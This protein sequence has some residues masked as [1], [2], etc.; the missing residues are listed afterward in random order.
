MPTGAIVAG[1]LRRPGSDRKAAFAGYEAP[2]PS[3]L[4]KAGA[5]RF[6]FCIPFAEPIL[7]QAA[8]QARDRKVL[9]QLTMPKHLMFGSADEI[10][11]EQSGRAWAA[12]LPGATFDAIP[13]AGHFVQEE[14][15][16]EI[17]DVLL[18][19]ATDS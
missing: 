12:S 13:G 8:E 17:V 10:F 5:R 18:A 4:Y 14:A 7:G 16:E 6:P 2:F 9:P 15:G 3:A 1:S 19:R 11:T